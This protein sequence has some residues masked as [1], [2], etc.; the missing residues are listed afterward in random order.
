MTKFDI[1]RKNLYEDLLGLGY[2]KDEDGTINTIVPEHHMFMGKQYFYGK[3]V[4]LFGNMMSGKGGMNNM[5]KYMMM[6]EMM[7]GFDAEPATWAICFP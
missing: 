6:T 1:N 3:I 4:S 2:F 7:K 5:V